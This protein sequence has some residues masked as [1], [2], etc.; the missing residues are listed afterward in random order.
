[1]SCQVLTQV[2]C[3]QAKYWRC[4]NGLVPPAVPAMPVRTDYQ[5]YPQVNAVPAAAQFVAVA[6]HQPHASQELS[7]KHNVRGSHGG[8]HTHS[9]LLQPYEGE[10]AIIDHKNNNDSLGRQ[11][12]QMDGSAVNSHDTVPHASEVMHHRLHERQTHSA[13]DSSNQDVGVDHV[14]STATNNAVV[15]SP[16]HKAARHSAD[17]DDTHG[18]RL[19][20]E[21][22]APQAH[23]AKGVHRNKSPPS[24]QMCQSKSHQ[25]LLLMRALHVSAH[26]Q[27]K[28]QQRHAGHLHGHA[29]LRVQRQNSI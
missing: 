19:L 22:Q 3:M 14:A 16:V 8:S 6:A 17:H 27:M 13:H 26:K 10:K 9:D 1:M 11:S 4:L 2:C 25:R 24:P 15:H 20:A 5:L 12:P 28:R 29:A 18:H 23:A 7:P 21:V